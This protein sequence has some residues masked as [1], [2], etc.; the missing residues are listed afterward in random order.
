[1]Q[2]QGHCCPWLFTTVFS[3]V[4]LLSGE[5]EPLIIAGLQIIATR[6][7]DLRRTFV[8]GSAIIFGLSADVVPQIYAPVHPW[9]QPI[10]SSSLA[11]GTVTAIVMNLLMR[12]GISSRSSLELL[13]GRHSSEEVFTFMEKQGSIWAA[14]R[15]VIMNAA[16]A[17][18]EVLESVTLLKLAKGLLNVEAKFDELNL[19]INITYEGT[20]L[21]FPEK[22]PSPE[23]LA[24][25]N[26]ALPEIP[27]LLC[28]QLKQMMDN[29]DSYILVDTRV[30]ASFILGYLPGAINIPES[31]LSPPFSQ[32]WIN[33]QLKALPKNETIIFYCD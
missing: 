32:E 22:P 14:R 7:L 12:I 23:E 16:G 8:L 17:L 1:M 18:N 29:G 31:D 20:L 26:F 21:Q 24:E 4:L 25:N 30:S 2:V 15:E 33:D 6:M 13:P 11:L 28:E 3:A 5:R 27:R 10:F 19:D 9:I